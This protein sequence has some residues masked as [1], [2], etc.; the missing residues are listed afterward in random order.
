MSS[1]IA[2]SKRKITNE[3]E[4]LMIDH[5]KNLAKKFQIAN[6]HGMVGF[7]AFRR[8]GLQNLLDQRPH[9]VQRLG[10][11]LTSLEQDVRRHFPL[12]LLPH[13][14]WRPATF[15]NKYIVSSLS[16]PRNWTPLKLRNETNRAAKTGANYRQHTAKVWVQNINFEILTVTSANFQ[17]WYFAYLQNH[18]S[19]R[20]DFWRAGPTSSRPGPAFCKY[21]ILSTNVGSMFP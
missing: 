3:E 13:Y 15:P 9:S 17:S 11:P 20:Q 12:Y 5:R 2:H 16:Y 10:L 4:K 19:A 7:T 21:D 1:I 6:R 8:P 14:Q 18:G